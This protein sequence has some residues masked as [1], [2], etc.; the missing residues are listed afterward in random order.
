MF[1]TVL[2]TSKLIDCCGDKLAAGATVLVE[3]VRKMI[4][5]PVKT[6]PNQL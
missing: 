2:C 6:S 1:F 3:E 5:Q 4:P